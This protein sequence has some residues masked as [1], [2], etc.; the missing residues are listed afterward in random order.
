MNMEIQIQTTDGETSRF[1]MND[2]SRAVAL[3]QSIKPREF[4]N[5]PLLH[6]QSGK[7]TSIYS[8][9]AIESVYFATSRKVDLRNQPGSRNLTTITEKEYLAGMKSLRRQYESNEK[10][11]E[12]GSS[13]DSLVAVHCVSG[14]MYYLHLEITVGLRV[15]QLM[16]MHNLLARLVSVVPC[17]PEGY[18]AINPHNTKKIE[19]YPAPRETTKSAWLVD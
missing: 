9:K 6:L 11:F 14:R 17:A 3:I 13:V 5:E 7:Q 19:I 15:E 18:I 1:A 16:D 12:P 10:L 4:F 8:M 2:E